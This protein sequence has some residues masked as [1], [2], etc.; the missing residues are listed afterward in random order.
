M[1]TAG[2][3]RL[4]YGDTVKDRGAVGVALRG[5][6]DVSVIV[7]QGCRPLG[8]IH[9]VTGVKGNVITQLDDETPIDVLRGVFAA[10]AEQDQEL[11]RRGVMLG[12]A[13]S[14]DSGER[15]RGGFLIRGLMGADAN[16]GAL[17][18]AGTVSEQDAVQFHVRDATTA[19]EDLELLLTPQAFEPDAAG[20]MLFTCN[21]RGSRM[22]DKPDG[23]ISVVRQALGVDVP[24]SGFFCGGELGPIGGTNFVHGYTASMAIFRP[25][26]ADSA[27]LSQS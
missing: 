25:K 27:S 14:P 26:Q 22:Y 20:A 5:A 21:G 16:S 4:A 15:G 18:V 2:G 23:D 17:A 10:A 3:N 8:P 13:I 12:H 11:M 7:S 6:I 24:V 9:T 19:Q 1:Q